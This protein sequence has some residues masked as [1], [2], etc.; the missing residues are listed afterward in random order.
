VQE[1]AVEAALTGNV[2]HVY[3]AVALDPLS[4]SL[5][6]LQQ[7]RDLTT[8]LLSAEA[9]WLPELRH[10]AD[11]DASVLVGG[12]TSDRPIAAVL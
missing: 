9:R 4:S 5:L 7:L 8:E 3:H 6:S 12:S 1:L 2:D 10:V 11:E